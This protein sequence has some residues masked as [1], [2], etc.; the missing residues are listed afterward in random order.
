MLE[1]ITKEKNSADHLLYVS[2]KYT[3][4]CDVILNLIERWE[5]LINSCFNAL[6]HYLIK[7][8]K[9]KT[10]P[11]S[12]IQKADLIRKN[13]KKFKEINEIVDLYLFFRRVPSLQ[14]IREGDFRKNV[15]LKIQIE[16]K[17]IEI[18][19]EKL[20]EYSLLIERFISFVKE[21]IS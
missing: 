19:L 9:I 3:K 13:F 7:T 1:D 17:T 14:K 16:G 21:K 2:L 12:P 18:N 10:S 8:K 15:N 5:S 20:K 6:I 4:T 11:G